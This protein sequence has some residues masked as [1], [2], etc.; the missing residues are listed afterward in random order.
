MSFSFS[1]N[2]PLEY[3]E[4]YRSQ[5]NCDSFG[6]LPEVVRYD[7]SHWFAA[8]PDEDDKKLLLDL[9][10]SGKFLSWFCS[11]CGNPVFEGSPDSWKDFQGTVQSDHLTFPGDPTRFTEDWLRAICDDCRCNS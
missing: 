10:L 1:G 8:K 2:L 3:T 6:E 4:E 11:N 5:V 7:L 9:Y